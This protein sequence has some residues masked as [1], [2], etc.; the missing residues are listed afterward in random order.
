MTAR[1]PC[2][3]LTMHGKC[4][5]RDLD[6]P[7]RELDVSP[8]SSLCLIKIYFKHGVK[9]ALYCQQGSGTLRQHL[10]MMQNIA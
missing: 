3:H 6:S 9:M 7:A 10:L 4:L 1:S 2:P 5:L 8:V